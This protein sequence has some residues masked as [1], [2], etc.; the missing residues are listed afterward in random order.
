[1]DEGSDRNRSLVPN[2]A[3]RWRNFCFHMMLVVLCTALQRPPVFRVTEAAS[4]APVT[5]IGV[6]HYNPSSVA[7]VRWIDG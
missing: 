5:L 3:S 6:M 2:G 4:S 1:L 7:V